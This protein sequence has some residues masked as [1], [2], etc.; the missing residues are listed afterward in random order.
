MRFDTVVTWGRIRYVAAAAAVTLLSAT[1]AASQP[2]TTVQCK[3]DGPAVAIPDLPEA[4]GVAIS[5][6]V[7]GRLWSHN[8]SGRATLVALDAKGAVTGRL[9][10]EGIKID[11]WEAVA[12]GPCKEGSCIY[13]GDIGDNNG[14]R[15]RIT[16]YRAAEPADG[17][18]T[19][20]VSET[21]HATYPDGGHDAES[22]FVAPDG[23]I[24]IVTKGDTG[25]VALYRFPRE[26]R[27]GST[28]TLERVAGPGGAGKPPASD[29]ITDAAMSPD[30]VWVVLRTNG[31]LTFF[32][33]ADLTAGKWI[34]AGRVDLRPVREPQG[35]GVAIG[36]NGALYLTS[37]GGGK[38]LP[39]TFARLT[40]TMGR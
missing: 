35:E 21:F 23:A 15:K 5:R 10:I 11:D 36:D 22:L 31:Q 19:V 20:R 1:Q 9:Q 6:R 12:V 16:V 30:G 8:D 27:S 29:R 38:Q 14:K 2:A 25:A 17:G 24:Y 7:P 40:C 37:E 3:P 33:F 18:A 32:R 34:E 4:S 39:G 28:H 13:V 26:L